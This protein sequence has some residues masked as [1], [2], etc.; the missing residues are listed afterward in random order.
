MTKQSITIDEIYRIS[1]KILQKVGVPAG[2]AHIVADSI[3]D[4]HRR[5]KGTH[6][7]PRLPIYVRKIQQ[8][9][10]TAG[11]PLTA[12]RESPVVSVLDAH[13][14]FG[15]VAG[16][17]GM[18]ICIQKAKKYGVGIVGIRHSNNFG[19]AGYIAEVASKSGLIGIVLGNSAP[20]MPPTGGVKPILGTNPLSISFPAGSS[21]I[22]ITLDMATSMAARGKIRLAA[23]NGE[24]IPLGWA[25]DE[26]GEPTDDPLKALKGSML[27][28]GGPKGYGLSLAIDLLAGMLP[29]AAFAGDVKGLNDPSQ[30]SNY[31]H[32][33]A[34]LNIDHFMTHH[35]YR[36]GID[37]LTE[38]V[39]NSGASNEVLLPGEGSYRTLCNQRQTVEITNAVA[40]EISL[41]AKKLDVA[42]I[43]FY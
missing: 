38:R 21:G 16:V 10:M 32:F 40:T 27:P 26:N 30:F 41:L 5:G 20:A 4:A 8:S 13:H 19:T 24:K 17:K 29:G 6:G 11:T 31:G 12:V 36:S 43:F 1:S 33:L 28:L 2:D 3:V 42:A 18:Q 39:K 34:A 25:I 9:L 35:E 7:L 22:P 23:K 15:Q 14:G 37:L